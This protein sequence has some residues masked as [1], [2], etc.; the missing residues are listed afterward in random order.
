[1]RPWH[2]F[3]ITLLPTIVKYTKARQ[4]PWLLRKA[5]SSHPNT[6][7][8]NLHPDAGKAARTPTL[9]TYAWETDSTH[10]EHVVQFVLYSPSLPIVHTREI[11]CRE[12][13]TVTYIIAVSDY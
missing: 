11:L 5:M 2:D 12:Q 10:M 3:S 7:E 1:M 8:L 9:P 6:T 4:K 13:H